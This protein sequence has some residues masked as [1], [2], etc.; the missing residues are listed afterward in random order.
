MNDAFS[1]EKKLQEL[2]ILFWIKM[3][4]LIKLFGFSSIL[5]TINDIQGGLQMRWSLQVVTFIFLFN[6]LTICLRVDQ[7][8][9]GKKTK[10]WTKR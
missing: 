3:H 9:I 8:N 4:P 1:I 2:S 10:R 6:A 5:L 7:Y